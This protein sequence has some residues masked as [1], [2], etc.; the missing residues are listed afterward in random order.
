DDFGTGYSSLPSMKKLHAAELKIDRSFVMNMT[1]SHEDMIIVRALVDLA[2]NMHLQVVAE[3]VESAE[4][5]EFLKGMGCDAVQGYHISRPLPV[6][7]V[8]KWLLDFDYSR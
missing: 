7:Q 8:G 2:R 6:E 5:L 4:S 1:A 3:G